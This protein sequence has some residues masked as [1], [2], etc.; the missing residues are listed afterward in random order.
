MPLPVS[1]PLHLIQAAAEMGLTPLVNLRQLLRSPGGA[2]P[3]TP[4]NAGVPQSG[5][6]NLLQ[7]L[8]ASG[9]APIVVNIIGA[10]V[11]GF[12]IS[13]ADATAGYQLNSSGAEQQ[14]T[15][16]GTTTIN[17]W[18]SS[19]SAASYDVMATLNSG[20]LT[21]GSATGVWLNLASTRNW[22]VQRTSNTPGSNSANLTIQIRPAGGGATIDSA[23]VDLTATVDA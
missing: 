16:S 3:D 12:T 5:T 13:P 17:T 8:G 20:A 11:N 21:G 14:F 4:G 2:T 15:Q 7:L 9:A 23:V 22:S 19:G 1:P 10:S 18:L 6:I